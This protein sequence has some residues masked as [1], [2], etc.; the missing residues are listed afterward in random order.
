MTTTVTRGNTVRFTAQFLDADGNVTAPP[1]A[2]LYV[3]YKANRLVRTDTVPMV[4]QTDDWS[5]TWNSGVADPG[6]AVWHVRSAG[7]T[8]SAADGDLLIVANEANP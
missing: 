5:A 8:K 1:S 3:R 2:N 7:A 6:S 4:A